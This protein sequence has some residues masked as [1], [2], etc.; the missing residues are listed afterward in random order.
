MFNAR[1]EIA[2]KLDIRLELSFALI[3]LILFQVRNE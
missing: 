1:L 2:K 3:H